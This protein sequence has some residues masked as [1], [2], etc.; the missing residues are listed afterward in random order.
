MK[1]LIGEKGVNELG[2]KFAGNVKIE[3]FVDAKFGNVASVKFK[4][5]NIFDRS[6][7]DIW[8]YLMKNC[9]IIKIIKFS[10]AFIDLH[11]LEGS[12]KFINALN[13]LRDKIKPIYIKKGDKNKWWWIG[14]DSFGCSRKCFRV[15]HL[16]KD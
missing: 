6:E 14:V 4:N 2:Q 7:L 8:D 3:K 12:E 10:K 11:M 5:A 13:M 9:E 15:R 1:V 16:F